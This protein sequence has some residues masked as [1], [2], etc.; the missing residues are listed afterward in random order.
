MWIEI[1]SIGTEV[2]RGQTVNKNAMDISSY[3]LQVGYTTSRHTVL[4]DHPD[5]L[6]KG[7]REVFDRADVIITTGGLG[8]TIDDGTKEVI[9]KLLGKKL[10]IDPVIQKDLKNRYANKE[11]ISIDNQALIPAGFE[12]IINPLGTAPALLLQERQKVVVMLPGVP[13]EMQALL[14][15]VSKRI[16]E[17]VPLEKKTY[18]ELLNFCLLPEGEIDAVLRTIDTSEV[19][20]GIYPNAGLVRISMTVRCSSK[21]KALKLFRPVQ[22][23]L[24]QHFSEYMFFASSGQIEEAVHLKLSATEQKLILAESCT[25]GYLATRFTKQPGAS[26]YFLG[27][28]VVYSNEMKQK[29]L[30]V[31][32]K[33]IDQHGAVSEQTVTEM[34]KGLLHISDADF[35]IAVSGTAGPS[36]GTKDKPVGT[37]FIGVQKRGQD[38]DI[39]KI[40]KKGPRDIVME[41][42]V[43]IALSALLRKIDKNLTT[44][45]TWT[46]N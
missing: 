3:F 45:K 16:E 24:E 32:P 9:A 10:M 22:K 30:Q 26:S 42:S 17:L 18:T 15:L 6:I 28:C 40:L 8:P 35:A 29:V 12:A 19:E 31:D 39:G 1:V 27:S 33:T 11:Y 2:L 36:G 44:L 41:Y 38:P 13:R 37:V 20:L 43:N 23:A 21:D 46:T 7:L 25:G 4:P 5:E 34:L 14:P